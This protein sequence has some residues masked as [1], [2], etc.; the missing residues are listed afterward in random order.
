MLAVIGRWVERRRAIRRRWQ[1]DAR[2]LADAD[3]HNAYYEAQRH[4][5]G[6]GSQR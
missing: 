3:V 4:A 1:A 5:A 2:A 6:P